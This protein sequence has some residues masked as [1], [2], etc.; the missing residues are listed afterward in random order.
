MSAAGTAAL[1]GIPLADAPG[2]GIYAPPSNLVP[3]GFLT[4]DPKEPPLPT[5]P[6]PGPNKPVP[7]PE[8][9][10]VALLVVGLGALAALRV[11]RTR[12]H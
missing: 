11:K 4:P 10:G 8:P 3:T 2:G 6:V 9:A 5:G 1:A 7:V 12:T